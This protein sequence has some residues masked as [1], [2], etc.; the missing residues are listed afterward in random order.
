MSLTW[1][2]NPSKSHLYFFPTTILPVL[3]QH[4][5]SNRFLVF[6]SRQY[7]IIII[8]Q[9]SGGGFEFRFFHKHFNQVINLLLFFC[10]QWVVIVTPSFDTKNWKKNIYSMF[11]ESAS[12]YIYIP[13]GCL[14]F[15][16]LFQATKNDLFQWICVPLVTPPRTC[17]GGVWAWA[18]IVDG[19]ELLFFCGIGSVSPSQMYGGTLPRSAVHKVGVTWVTT[20]NVLRKC[21]T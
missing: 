12:I 3:S 6:H 18:A 16:T 9:C 15:R 4:H 19:H 8:I 13:Y 10:C 14:E 1:R 5:S 11:V 7:T 20:Y 21:V 2:T 17:V